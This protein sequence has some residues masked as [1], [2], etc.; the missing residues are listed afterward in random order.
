MKRRIEFWG[1]DPCDHPKVSV[2]VVAKGYATDRNAILAA[3]KLGFEG[4]KYFK[5]EGPEIDGLFA[6]SDRQLNAIAE[7]TMKLIDELDWDFD[8][9]EPER[10]QVELPPSPLSTA[11]EV[12]DGDQDFQ[13]KDKESWPSERRLRVPAGGSFSPFTATTRP[14]RRT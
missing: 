4:F 2:R 13:D 6:S 1:I 9:D 11:T 7:R 8:G 14:A 3:L 5:D 10:E 12:S